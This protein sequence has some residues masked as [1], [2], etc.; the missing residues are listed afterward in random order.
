MGLESSE[1]N[2]QCIG[3]CRIVCEVS[4]DATVS[5]D[6]GLYSPFTGVWARAFSRANWLDRGVG[7]YLDNYL[8]S[9]DG[10]YEGSLRCTSRYC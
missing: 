8:T 5:C 2:S 10:A 7:G 1:R 9:T 6:S 4:T 3:I